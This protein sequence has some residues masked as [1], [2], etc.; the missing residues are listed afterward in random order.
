MEDTS[1]ILLRVASH[2]WPSPLCREVATGKPQISSHS[3]NHCT[4]KE[5]CSVQFTWA[6]S[7]RCMEHRSE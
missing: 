5:K 3:R 1:I 7:A 4:L 6:A 2:W